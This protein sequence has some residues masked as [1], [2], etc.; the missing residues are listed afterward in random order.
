MAKEDLKTRP[1]LDDKTWIVWLQAQPENR[2][3]D[4]AGLYRKMLEWCLKKQ[5]TPTRRRLLR[6]LDTER[7][8]LPMDYTPPYFE[9]PVPETGECPTCH[10][11]RRIKVNDLSSPCPK[12]RPAEEKAFWRSRGR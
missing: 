4:V 5:I 8:A 6:W 1:D 9:P 10:N 12:C 7:E 11:D 2:K 3:L